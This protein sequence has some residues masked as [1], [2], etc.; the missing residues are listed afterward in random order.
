MTGAGEG[1][2]MNALESGWMR[3][4]NDDGAGTRAESASPGGIPVVAGLF[5]R[6]KTVAASGASALLLGLMVVA[7]RPATYTATT[8]LLVYNR[9]FRPGPEPVVTPGPADTP[10]VENVIEIFRSPGVL[11]RVVTALG[12]GNDAEFV[13]VSPL[14]RLAGRWFASSPE[15]ASAEDR[16]AVERALAHFQKRLTVARI[17]ASHAVGVSFTAADPYKAAQVANEI[18]RV[19]AAVVSNA[20]SRTALLR[21]R[22]QR[23]GPSAL[24]I[25]VA[26]PP[27]T[28]DGPAKILILLGAIVIGLGTGVA[29]AL[30]REF[31]DRSV[32]TGGQIEHA[33][34][35]ECLAVVSR[36]ACGAGGSRPKESD[37]G[38]RSGVLAVLSDRYQGLRRARVVIQSV[39]GLR[40]IGVTSVDPEEG[41]STVA[42][43]IALS[44]ALAG[45]RVLLAKVPDDG[46][47]PLGAVMPVATGP[48][49]P[50]TTSGS[51]D[52]GIVAGAN[53]PV[54]VLSLVHH[55]GELPQADGRAKRLDEVLVAAK[56]TYDLVVVDLP[57][58]A[59]GSEAR[60]VAPVV[61]GLLLVLQWGSSDLGLAE[62]RLAAFG[63]AR[64]KFF[65]AILDGADPRLIG[66][67]GD[68][69]A[70]QTIVAPRQASSAVG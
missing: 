55:R 7:V 40:V 38:P 49:T 56:G 64:A 5:R 50:M 45:K 31:T 9:E 59:S 37:G 20:D 61:D 27:V 42:A 2:R 28:P 36:Q 26:D 70:A 12:L 51:L 69:L 43:Q 34:G 16:V 29:L 35:L 68:R 60:M 65:G 3:G 44:T 10:L 15:P 4:G 19:A 32:R 47:S 46:D 13:Y 17:A 11:T 30:L 14:A 67:Y 57:S 39:R 62:R 58:L 53:A 8:E 1:G 21:E 18:A 24:V 63:T 6:W 23:L 25:S 33:L 52:G 54:D 22:L 41:A 48:V 66:R